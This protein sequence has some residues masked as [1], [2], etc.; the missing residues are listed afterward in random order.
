GYFHVRSG[1]D[2]ALARGLAYAPHADVIWC[3]TQ[4]PDLREARTFAEGMHDAFP[5]KLLAYNCSPSFNWERNLDAHTIAK[6]QREL[7]AMGYAFQFITLAGW[8]LINLHTFQLAKS[9][10]AEGMPAYVRLQSQEF[11]L[12]PEGYTGTQHQRESGTG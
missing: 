12:E 3:E 4:T 2:A 6:F 1:M 8:H 11:A 5:G 10:A 7:A 9:Y